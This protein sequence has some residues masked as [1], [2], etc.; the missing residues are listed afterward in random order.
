[1]GAKRKLSDGGKKNANNASPEDVKGKKKARVSETP[2]SIALSKL[3]AAFEGEIGTML[4]TSVNEMVKSVADKCLLSTVETRDEI[5]TTFAKVVGQALE[6]G[7]EG[8]KKEHLDAIAAVETEEEKVKTLQSELD[9]AN[10]LKEQADKALDEATEAQKQ[11]S[12]KKMEA[13]TELESHLEEE[14]GLT[15]KKNLMEGDLQ[16]LKEVKDT[17]RGP[18]NPGK[19]EVQKLQKALKEVEA[20][21]SLIAGIGEAIGKQSAFDQHF[22]GEA[23]KL[24]YDKSTQI[25]GELAKFSETVK[26]AADKSEVLRG[27]VDQLTT[28]LGERDTELVAAK[29]KQK[30]CIA[31]IKEAEKQK[32]AGDKSLEKAIS[33]KDEKAAAEGVGTDAADQYKFLLERTAAVIAEAPEAPMAEVEVEAA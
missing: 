28:D 22:V 12:D 16:A 14:N 13:E 15:P 25:E 8:L 19:K 7:V 10:T 32:K 29:K 2:E 11:A 4:P 17:V 3:I 27:K 31:A 18:S 20:P 21:Q 1:M 30:E 26:E 24:L 5:E 23:A 6:T 33:Y 9:S